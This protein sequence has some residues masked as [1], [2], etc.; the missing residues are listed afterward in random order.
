MC[1]I[2]NRFV[3]DYRNLRNNDGKLDAKELRQLSNLIVNAGSNPQAVQ[4]LKNEIMQDGR[5]DDE[6]KKLLLTIGFSSDESTLNEIKSHL[7]PASDDSISSL[8][9]KGFK[10]RGQ[11][12][13]KYRAENPNISTVRDNA[14]SATNS[15]IGFLKEYTPDVVRQGVNK[16]IGRDNT[17]DSLRVNNTTEAAIYKD[18]KTMSRFFNEDNMRILSSA[19][20]RDCV[21]SALKAVGI[22]AKNSGSIEINEGN[23][24][25]ITG[26]PWDAINVAHYKDNPAKMADLL[27]GQEGKAIVVV[28]NHTFVYQG[29]DPQGNIKVTDPSEHNVKRL[30][31]KDNPSAT[32]YVQKDVG[33]G[34]DGA[35]SNKASNQSAAVGFNAFKASNDK[36]QVNSADRADKSGESYNIRK[37]MV[38]LGDKSQSPTNQKIF[39][40]IENGNLGELQRLLRNQGINIQDQEMKAFMN[41]MNAPVKEPNGKTT[42]ILN[43]LKSLSSKSPAER[44]QYLNGVEFSD[45]NLK[46][47]FTKTNPQTIHST[48]HDI[49]CGRDGC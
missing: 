45:I 38:L 23:L 41:V 46:D 19:E 10:E 47:Y 2:S 39:A 27:K 44:A 25:K 8:L 26:K 18:D 49:L 12:V 22:V 28:G 21:N 48:L 7:S 33:K 16:V 9:E 24:K 32:V 34:G 1:G 35:D 29:R 37:L 43:D 42:T 30:I 17:R 14:S 36:A 6:E 15:V 3:S 31:N 11:A 40:A 5:L 20:K 4:A 13:N